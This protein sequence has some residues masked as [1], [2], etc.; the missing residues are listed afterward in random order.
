MGNPQFMNVHINGIIVGERHRRDLGDPMGLMERIK[1]IG[2]L[3]P[4]VLT[5]EFELIAGF[6]AGVNHESSLRCGEIAIQLPLRD[7]QAEFVPFARLG[8]H[9]PAVGVLAQYILDDFIFL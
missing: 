7:L 9:E 6:V 5:P 1:E 4:I 2:L 8:P 3:H